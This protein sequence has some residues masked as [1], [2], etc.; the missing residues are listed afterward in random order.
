MICRNK[1]ILLAMIAG[2]TDYIGSVF[3][4]YN[5]SIPVIIRNVNLL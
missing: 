2:L 5:I 4:L 1:V 3:L